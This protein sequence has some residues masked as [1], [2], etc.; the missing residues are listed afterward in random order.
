[1]A[2]IDRNCEICG[3][4]FM[5][6]PYQLKRGRGKLCSLECGGRKASLV[7]KQPIKEANPN[8]K[9]GIHKVY[10][11]DYRIKNPQKA[12]AHRLLLKA[13]RRG[14]LKRLPCEKCSSVKSHGHHEDYNKPLEVIWL[15]PKNHVQRHKEINMS[16]ISSCGLPSEFLTD[17]PHQIGADAVEQSVK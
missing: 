1:M 15:C 2:K 3:K 10:G 12:E 6:W 16:H 8:W 7:R 11:K 17:R 13:I 5:A 4:A 14:D 9:G